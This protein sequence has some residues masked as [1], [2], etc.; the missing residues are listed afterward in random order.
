MQT[1]RCRQ[2]IKK[3]KVF[4]DDTGIDLWAFDEVRFEQHGTCCRMWIP[5]E[6]KE[7]FVLH[8]PTRNSVGYFGAVRLRD[9]KF[10]YRRE[11]GKFNG[12]TFFS[13]LKQLRRISSR[14]GRKVVMIIDNARYHHA[15][16]HAA[17][18]EKNKEKFA[19]EF[20]PP[21]SPELNPIERVWKLTRRKGT[22]NRYF[23][24]IQEIKEAVEEVFK[25]WRHKSDILRRLCAIN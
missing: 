22:H 15:Q 8:C 2:D 23:S 13:F 1:L 16:L 4:R 24:S 9:G 19:F 11:D 3:L 12:M 7:P 21:Y 14:S 6:V 5:P 18:R 17:W 20:M 10:V 25:S